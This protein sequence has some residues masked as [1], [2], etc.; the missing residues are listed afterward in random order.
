[1]VLNAV[2][3]SGPVETLPIL[4]VFHAFIAPN[5]VAGAHAVTVWDPASGAEFTGSGLEVVHIYVVSFFSN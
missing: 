4:G 3:R 2:L 5:P 1:M